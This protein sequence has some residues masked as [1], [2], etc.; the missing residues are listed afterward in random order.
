MTDSAA[1]G[2]AAAPQPEDRS[3]AGAS[4]DAAASVPAVGPWIVTARPGLVIE[5]PFALAIADIA[6]RGD[7]LYLQVGDRL[8]VIKGYGPALDAGHAPAVLDASGDSLALGVPQ[9]RRRIA[10]IGRQVCNRCATI[11]HSWGLQ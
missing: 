6:L 3:P 4:V 8:V 5:L 9:S 2:A 10:W 7:D 1:S 11:L